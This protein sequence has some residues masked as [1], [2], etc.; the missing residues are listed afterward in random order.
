MTTTAV[1]LE[2]LAQRIARQQAELEALRHEY[3]AR[4][5]RLADLQRRKQHLEGQLR[6]LDE[7]IQAVDRGKTLQPYSAAAK[8]PPAKPPVA[9]EAAKSPRPNTLPALLVHLVGRAKGPITVKQLA[10][11]VE[12]QKFPTS[13][14]NV[15]RLVGTRVQGL[16]A[17]G[18]FQRAKGQPGVVLVR[19]ESA[20]KAPAAKTTAAK[21]GGKKGAVSSKKSPRKGPNGRPKK[22]LRVI[23]TDLL[24]KSRRP[25]LARE[26]GEQAKAQGYETE[27]EDFVRV[28]WVMLGKMDNVENVPGQGYRLKKR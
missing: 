13:S 2:T 7:E 21:A 24:A 19:P 8:A 11:E 4:Q 16:M 15:A 10:D 26:L 20:T 5:T 6:Q 12:Q 17:K 9:V 23:L 18:V 28:I 27:S 22:P 1:P 25:L 3:A 14:K